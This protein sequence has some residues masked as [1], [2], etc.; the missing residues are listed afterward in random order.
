MRRGTFCNQS[1]IRKIGR[2]VVERRRSAT[3]ENVKVNGGKVCTERDVHA[4]QAEFLVH[5]DE[6]LI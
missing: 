3:N 6:S 1:R 5:R 2:L 4:L